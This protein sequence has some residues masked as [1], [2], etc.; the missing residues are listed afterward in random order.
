MPKI[1]LLGSN[2]DEPEVVCALGPSQVEH[3]T[4]AAVDC[5]ELDLALQIVDSNAVLFVFVNR[6][7]VSSA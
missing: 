6:C 5:D 4:L 3:F 1:E 2:C 7:N